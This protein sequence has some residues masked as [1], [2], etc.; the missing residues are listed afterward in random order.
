MES[1]GEERSAQDT[2]ATLQLEIGEPVKRSVDGSE[3]ATEALEEQRAANGLG[4]APSN[5]LCFQEGGL[6]H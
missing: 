6:Q 2:E 1:R 4:N 3:M 5:P